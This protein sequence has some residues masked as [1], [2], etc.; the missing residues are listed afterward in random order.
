MHFGAKNVTKI[1]DDITSERKLQLDKW[2]EQ[3][4]DDEFWHLILSE[5]VGEVA[6]AILEEGAVELRKELVSVAAVAVA[7]VELL[8][9]IT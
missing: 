2:G 8:D 1:F 7:W 4:H 3:R 5:E 9:S 6:K